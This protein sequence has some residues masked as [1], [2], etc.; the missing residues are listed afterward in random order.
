MMPVASLW[1][2]SVGAALA[3]PC[4]GMAEVTACYLNHALLYCQVEVKAW[5]VFT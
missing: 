2:G 1:G 3:K 4:G 5:F